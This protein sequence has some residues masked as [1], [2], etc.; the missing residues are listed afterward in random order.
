M[1]NQLALLNEPALNAR[2]RIA[3]QFAANV[4]KTGSEVKDKVKTD[5]GNKPIREVLKELFPTKQEETWL[6][7]VR[8]ILGEPVANLDDLELEAY[9]TEFEYLLDAWMDQFEKQL[10][11][12]KTLKEVVKEV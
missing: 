10:F 5:Y 1:P 4:S 12:N 2:D 7:R 6:K 9:L 11:D 8:R 3:T